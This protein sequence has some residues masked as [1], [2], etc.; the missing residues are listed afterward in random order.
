MALT[1]ACDDENYIVFSIKVEG[2]G[3]FGT[4]RYQLILFQI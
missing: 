2:K 4:L 1:E 3:S